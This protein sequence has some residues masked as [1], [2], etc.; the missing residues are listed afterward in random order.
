MFLLHCI[1][2]CL[3]DGSF[4]P[5]TPQPPGCSEWWRP[6]CPLS[7]K[8]HIYESMRGTAPVARHCSRCDI[9]TL[10]HLKLSIASFTVWRP[11]SNL[12]GGGRPPSPLPP[13]FFPFFFPFFGIAAALACFAAAKGCGSN[14]TAQLRCA[15]ARNTNSLDG[16][17]NPDHRKKRRAVTSCL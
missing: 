12:G 10:T 2:P 17:G 6:L 4:F 5:Y 1:S 9:L 8:T 16:R 14:R 11:S 3:S 15:H 7:Y 13:P